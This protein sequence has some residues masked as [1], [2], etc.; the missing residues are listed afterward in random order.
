MSSFAKEMMNEQKLILAPVIK[1][2]ESFTVQEMFAVMQLH[3][4]QLQRL[5]M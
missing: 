2:R 5:R 1:S 3:L 4:L